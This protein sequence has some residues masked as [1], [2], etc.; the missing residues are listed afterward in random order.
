MVA[1][2]IHVEI[3]GESSAD[4]LNERLNLSVLQHPVGPGPLD[5][6]DLSPDGEDGHG[7]RIAGLNSRATGRVTLHDEQLGFPR[8][9]RGAV[10]ELVRH[11][12]TIQRRLPPSRPARVLGCY[13]GPLSING[14]LNDG[15]GLLGVLLQPI[16]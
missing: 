13:P 1:D 12:G 3:L 16:S 8:I 9:L 5:V 10:L 7:V 11:T 15:L 2:A 6:E 14:L 4:C